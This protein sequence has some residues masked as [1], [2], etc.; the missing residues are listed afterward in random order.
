MENELYHSGIKGMKWGV[1]RTP[2]QL[3]HIRDALNQSK[4]IT[5]SVS[6]IANNTGR[7]KTN[8]K[9]VSSMSD[10]E[11]RKRVNRLNLEQQYAK[12][13]TSDVSKGQQVVSDILTTAGGIFGI[14]ASAAAIMLAVKQAKG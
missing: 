8:V 1:H 9:D 10:E 13:T 7:R 14:G 4:Q 2:E 5:E 11:L 12:L 6:K 3:G